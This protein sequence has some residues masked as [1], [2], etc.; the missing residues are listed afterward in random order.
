[1]NAVLILVI[2]GFCAA[3]TYGLSA[4]FHIGVLGTLGLGF[5]ITMI[6]INVSGVMR[7]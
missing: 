4:A 7:S 1:M 2:I 5:V 6:V 3:C